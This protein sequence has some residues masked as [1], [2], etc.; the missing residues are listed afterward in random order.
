M[1]TPKSEKHLPNSENWTI[2]GAW[3]YS[4]SSFTYL[5]NLY[6]SQTMDNC[7]MLQDDFVY[8]WKACYRE[9]VGRELC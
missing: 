6:F 1:K 4:I 2:Q 7:N 9:T 8:Y 3:E 5:E